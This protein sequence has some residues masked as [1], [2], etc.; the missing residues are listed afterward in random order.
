MLW[1]WRK[2]AC[3]YTRAASAGDASLKRWAPMKRHVDTAAAEEVG[4][5]ELSLRHDAPCFEIKALLVR[6]AHRERLP[7]Q[8]AFLDDGLDEGVLVHRRQ[9]DSHGLRVCGTP[10]ADDL[11]AVHIIHRSL[12]VRGEVGI[13]PNCERRRIE[14]VGRAE[15]EEGGALPGAPTELEAVGPCGGWDCARVH[16]HFQSLLFEEG[17]RILQEGVRLHTEDQSMD[18]LELEAGIVNVLKLNECK[19]RRVVVG[20]AFA[21]QVLP[22]TLRCS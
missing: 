21:L 13:Q 6:L 20:G 9:Q 7:R 17:L 19:S 10:L 16:L 3:I 8:Y 4:A 5:V 18:G 1:R 12:F 2:W 11:L 15:D 14:N 22:T